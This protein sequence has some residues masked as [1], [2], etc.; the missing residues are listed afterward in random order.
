MV[1]LCHGDRSISWKILDL[2][3]HRR[4]QMVNVLDLCDKVGLEVVSYFD[5]PP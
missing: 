4:D 3:W 2:S 5:I 1:P